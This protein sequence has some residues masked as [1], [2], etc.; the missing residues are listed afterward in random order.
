[1]YGSL[2]NSSHGLEPQWAGLPVAL[3]ALQVDANSQRDGVTK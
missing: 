1:M 2:M 3:F